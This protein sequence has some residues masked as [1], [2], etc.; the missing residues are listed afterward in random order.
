VIAFYAYLTL[1]QKVGPTRSSYVGIA[2][3][4]VALAL[5]TLFEGYRWTWIA[6]LGVV[7]AVV[8][9]WIALRSPSPQPLSPHA[10]TGVP[11]GEGPQ[12]PAQLSP[13]RPS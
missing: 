7:L 9:N 12:D 1:M 4:V 3:P 6:V 10:G 5:S 13:R 2:V 8:A 11:K